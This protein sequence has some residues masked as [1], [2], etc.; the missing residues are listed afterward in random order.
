MSIERH[1]LAIRVLAVVLAV[2]FIGVEV[3]DAIDAAAST[4]R[5]SLP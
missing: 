4:L 3:V 5:V 1:W 2:A